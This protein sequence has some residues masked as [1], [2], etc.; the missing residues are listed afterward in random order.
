MTGRVRGSPPNRPGPRGRPPRAAAPGLDPAAPGLARHEHQCGPPD[1]P[2][3]GP[4][5]AGGHSGPP[6]PP[7]P[8][9]WL[10]IT[11]E[12]ADD[13]S[14]SGL[15]PGP[16]RIGGLVTTTTLGRR[17]SR[18]TTVPIEQR[19][20]RTSTGGRRA[21]P[22]GKKHLASPPRASAISSARPATAPQARNETGPTIERPGSGRDT[23]GR[24]GTVAMSVRARHVGGG[25]L[26]GDD[27]AP[28]RLGEQVAV[29]SGSRRTLPAANRAARRRSAPAAGRRREGR[30]G[31]ASRAAG[32][33]G[34]GGT[35]IPG[36][37]PASTRAPGAARR[38]RWG[39]RHR[40]RRTT[41]R[42]AMARGRPINRSCLGNPSP[43]KT[44]SG[45]AAVTLARTASIP[46]GVASKPIGGASAPATVRPG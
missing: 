11:T 17:R 15:R 1:H 35:P 12:R 31:S 13:P 20:Q 33:L 25:V 22:S 43:T 19:T 38:R 24:T 2:A 36:R 44:M 26:V 45:P 28:R 3:V 4:L 34:P 30:P 23:S 8:P 7:N 16:R 27:L 41:R 9:G 37:P 40:R 10:S 5:Q 18:Y 21:E 29:Q 14:A 6:G 39:S 32:A 46:S 42:A